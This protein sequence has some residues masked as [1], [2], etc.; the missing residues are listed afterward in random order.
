MRL[1]AGAWKLL[2]L[3]SVAVRHTGHDETNFEMLRRLW[4]GRR[5]HA[6]GMLLRVS[7]FTPWGQL[8]RRKLRYILL[9]PSLHVAPLLSAGLVELLGAQVP[10][11]FIALSDFLLWAI[12]IASLAIRKGSVSSAVQ[13][14][15]TW[16]WYAIASLLGAWRSV[17]DPTMTIPSRV[18]K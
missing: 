2:R 17:P 8:V 10:W 4:H 1:V 3:S 14:V 15:F 16:H 6:A 9:V 18:I 12:V 5:M 7:L 11:L 13:S